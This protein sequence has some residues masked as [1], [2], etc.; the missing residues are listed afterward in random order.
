MPR[1][2]EL[3]AL[4]SEEDHSGALRR[5]EQLMAAKPGTPAGDELEVLSILVEQYE[6]QHFAVN[7]P[8]A[9]D[10][11]LFRMEQAG[12]GRKDLEPILG[13]RSRVSEILNGKRGLTVEMIRRLHR[14]IG[15]PL[16]SLV[17]T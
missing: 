8:T 10:A 9:I 12:L 17:G 2:F 15:I 5:I 1:R 6:K 13:G 3:R 7:P 4:H 16:E 14:E 11:I